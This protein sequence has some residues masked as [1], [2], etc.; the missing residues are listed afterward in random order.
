MD[1]HDV[2]ATIAF[3][4]EGQAIIVLGG[5]TDNGDV[6]W[7]AKAGEPDLAAMR[8]E[9]SN[10]RDR[11]ASRPIDMATRSSRERRWRASFG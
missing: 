11:I 5:F 8:A 2:M 7:N 10:R 9:G 4:E 1:D 6:L 3:K